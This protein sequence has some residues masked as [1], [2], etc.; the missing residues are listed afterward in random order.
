MKL[1]LSWLKEFVSIKPL[2]EQ[3]AER[4]TMAGIEVEEVINRGQ[5][6][7]KV[8]VGQVVD[9]KPHPNADKL[10]LAYVLTRPSGQ[11]QEIVCGAPNVAV[12]Q[13]VAVALL[14]AKLPNGL[15]VEARQIRG[16][17]SQ[18]M[19][20][21][22]RELGLGNDQSG[23]MVLDPKLEVGTSFAKAMG[24]DGVV[25]EIAVPANRGDLMSVRGLAWEVAAITGAKFKDQR[26]RLAESKTPA[27]R[28]VRLKIEA[29]KLCP[30]YTAR[31]IR[32][33]KVKS[34]PAWLQQRL[35]LAGVRPINAIVDVT[36]YVM[37]EYGQ[38]LH[39]FD[40]AKVR[41]RTIGVRAA[42]AGERLVTLDGVERKLQPS[43]LVIADAQGPIA[44]AG[45]MGG[46]HTEI[47][48][49]TTDVILESA[50]FDP[51][52]VRKTSR[53][54]GL[55]SESSLRFEKGIPQQLP[56]SASAAAAALMV[57]L[58]GGTVDKGIIRAGQPLP[59]PT[60][61]KMSPDFISELLGVDVPAAKAK[62]AL[63]RLGFTVR[64]SVKQWNVTVPFWRRDVSLSEDVVEEVGRMVGYDR[65]PE[66]LP[67]IATVPLPIPSLVRLKD[68]IR[69]ILVQLGLTEVMTHAFYGEDWAAAVGGQHYAI[70]NPLDATQ[71]FLRRS[72]I[73]HLREVLERAVDAGQDARVFEIGRVFL[74]EHAKNIEAQQPWK[75]V[76]GLA[77][78]VHRQSPPERK[79]TG[80]VQSLG[81][82]LSAEGITVSSIVSSISKGRVILVGELGVAELRK[83]RHPKL[84]TRLPKFP[85]VERDVSFWLKENVRYAAI[86]KTVREAGRPLL[87]TIELFDVFEQEGR[88]SYAV[89]LT[90]RS[91][92]RTLT[93]PEISAKMKAITAKLQVLGASLR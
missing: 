83:R 90:F 74:P 8:V 49:M 2:V 69:D 59:K 6:F 62:Q 76:I 38:P 36:N 56:A 80:V 61:V 37:L 30:V 52:S 57:K 54:L 16:V 5:D 27:A 51:V 64:G 3:L 12:G 42:K 21:S 17:A 81:E 29:A 86:E 50:V 33:L 87:E 34:S 7:E 40:A 22:E 20:C 68:E 75:L 24:F 4:L 1:P 67:Q 93:E 71:H 66:A 35:R 11:P 47:S 53:Q 79:L 55:T 39:A 31:V 63:S 85:A 28:S 43:T 70:A 72:L 89:H 18:G 65:L 45:V 46:A 82:G 48:D 32:G 9:L 19:V 23:I 92:G 91:P 13:K 10:R 14:G 60:A 73:P 58:C 44:L 41:S 25:L 78:K 88:R 84:F 77:H 26:V 15:M